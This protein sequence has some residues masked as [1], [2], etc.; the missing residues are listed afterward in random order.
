MTI[1]LGHARAIDAESFGEPGQRTFRIRIEGAGGEC[2]ALWVEKEQVQ[3]LQLALK[4]MLA[5]L[6]H[7]AGTPPDMSGFP[8]SANHEFKVG[9]MSMGFDHRDQ[10]V[11]LQMYDIESSEDADPVLSTKLAAEQ[12][13]TLRIQLLEI[14]EGGRPL[15]PLCE[16]A[17]DP[18]GHTCIRSNGHSKQP[19]PD[20]GNDLDEGT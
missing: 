18:S 9:R 3:A 15:C 4:Q 12:C 10:K 11:I 1:D 19:I 14:I 17:I 7:E 5:Q 20:S 6:D 8:V 2:A 16:A 13:A